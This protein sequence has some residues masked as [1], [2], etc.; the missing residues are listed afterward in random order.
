MAIPRKRLDALLEMWAR[1]V[2]QGHILP[3]SASIMEVMI[4][5]KG[6][7]CFGSG[8]KKRQGVDDIEAEIEA[9]V[10]R[11]A[12]SSRPL[13]AQ[14]LRVEYA[15]IRLRGIPECSDQLHKA[16]ALG[17]TLQTYRDYLSKA[18]TSVRNR[19]EQTYGW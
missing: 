17:I 13:M 6:V 2:H 16:H 15:A 14:V 4:A 18:R 11:L 5:N 8:G 10:M 3:P 9:E 7:M 1:W 12:Q 19:L